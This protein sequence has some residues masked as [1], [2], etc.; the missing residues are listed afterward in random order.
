MVFRFWVIFCVVFQFFF[1]RPQR[2]HLIRN[3]GDVMINF[4]SGEYM[5]MTIFQSVTQVAW[6]EK[7]EYSK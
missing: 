2:P 6:K 3:D 7:S 1:Y 5:R 4:E